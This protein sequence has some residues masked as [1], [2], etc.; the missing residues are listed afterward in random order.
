MHQILMLM[1][2]KTA[3]PAAVAY[4]SKSFGGTANPSKTF[5]AIGIGTASADR[6]VIVLVAVTNSSTH[7]LSSVTVAGQACTIV[8]QRNVTNGGTA[9]IVI[10][11]SPVT[12]GTTADVVVTLSGTAAEV[13]V[14]TFA[15]TGL[16]ST[17][18]TATAST[19]T[20]NGSMSLAVNAG[21][22]AIGCGASGGYYGASGAAAWTN[23]TGRFFDD[24]YTHAVGG[25]FAGASDTSAGATL[26][27]SCD[28]T[29]NYLP[30]FCVAAFR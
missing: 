26:S 15:A 4:V 9:A 21:G 3:A 27:I 20:N 25:Y 8:V 30:A 5:S 13:G 18:A 28:I 23:L 12:S 14:A 16:A 22:I 1:S 2:P 11:D 29:D 24:G 17:A 10:T 7:T 6:H 19:A